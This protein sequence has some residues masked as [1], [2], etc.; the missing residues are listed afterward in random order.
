MRI[1]GHRG[2][3]AHYPENTFAAFEAALIAGVA[4]I[5]LD[6]QRC[7]TGEMLVIHD[8]T[9]DRTTNGT[10]RVADMSLADLK[11]LETTNGEAL[12]NL[13]A[14]LDHLAGRKA[15]LFIELKGAGVRRVAQRIERSVLSGQFRYRQLP[16]ISF[17]PWRLA[18]LKLILPKAHTG[19][20]FSYDSAP[21]AGKMLFLARLIRAKAI[22]PDYRLVTPELVARGHAAGL[23]V[24]VW[25]VNAEADM[26]RMR[27]CGVNAIMTDDPAL[28]KRV[29]AA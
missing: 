21:S 20:S 8:A 10:G 29:L 6:V 7:K 3:S 5:E 19:L 24:N 15:A 14:L 11:Q 18:L 22:N 25:T 16:V 12:F 13:D 2:A 27:D 4:G 9:L 28:C 17:N 23:Q 26:L 1:I